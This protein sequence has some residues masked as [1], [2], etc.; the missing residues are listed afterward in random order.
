MLSLLPLRSRQLIIFLTTIALLIYSYPFFFPR[1]YDS[2][3]DAD[4]I[5]GKFES[6][7]QGKALFDYLPL[8][9]QQIPLDGTGIFYFPGWTSSS[10]LEVDNQTGLIIGPPSDLRWKETPFRLAMD[11][12]SLFSLLAYLMYNKA[13][14]KKG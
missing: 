12:V 5:S 4:F 14:G 10:Q 11:F 7:Q 1:E 2:Y 6:E 8:T 3:Q 13:Y 9:V